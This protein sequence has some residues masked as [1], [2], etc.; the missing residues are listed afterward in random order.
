MKRVIASIDTNEI[1]DKLCRE[2]YLKNTIAHNSYCWSNYFES[3]FFRITN[4]GYMTEYEVK[5]SRSDFK[6]DFQKYSGTKVIRDENGEVTDIEKQFKHDTIKNG[7]SGLKNFYFCT[8]KGLLDLEEIPEHC[9]L[10]E[11]NNSELY[12]GFSQMRV[13]KKAP[14]LKKA[15]KASDSMLKRIILKA[16]YRLY[17]EQLNLT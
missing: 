8:P 1:I 12:A 6:A 14:S 17:S 4:A 9:G 11:F 2:Y 15:K 3:G 10:I 16:Y 13:I 7:G 5:V